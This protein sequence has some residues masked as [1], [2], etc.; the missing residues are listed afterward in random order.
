M[1]LDNQRTPTAHHPTVPPSGEQ[2]VIVVVIIGAV[3]RFN[4]S[5]REN[6][7]ARQNKQTH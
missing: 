1:V 6:I 7:P 2:A 5:F 4:H 3:V